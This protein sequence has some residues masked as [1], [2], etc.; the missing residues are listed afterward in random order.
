MSVFV[1]GVYRGAGREHTVDA[2][3]ERERIT[4]TR[5]EPYDAAEEGYVQITIQRGRQGLNAW[6]DTPQARELVALLTRALAEGAPPPSRRARAGARALS[7]G[8]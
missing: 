4:V 7:R 8:R 6:I 5:N 1:R 3:F 2:H